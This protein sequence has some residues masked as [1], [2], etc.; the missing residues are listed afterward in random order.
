MSR[1]L[2]FIFL[3]IILMIIGCSQNNLTTNTFT[4]SVN[5]Q[6]I[7]FREYG[8]NN[9][10]E[11]LFI[12]G[13]MGSS[14]SFTNVAKGIS[15]EFNVT[16][17]DLP[18][19]GNSG[20]EIDFSID[21]LTELVDEFINK[22]YTK[23]V[24]LVGYSLGG[25]IANAI[26]E[27][28]NNKVNSYVLIDPWFSNNT[29]TDSLAFNF[30]SVIEKNAKNSWATNNDSINYVKEMNPD[31]SEDQINIISNNRFDYDI[32]I[33][34]SSVQKGTL[35]RNLNVPSKSPLLLIKPAASLIK[36]SQ[37]K[38]LS[39]NFL[40]LKVQAIPDTTHMIIFEEP[41]SISNL[42]KNFIK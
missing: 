1:N 21:K 31:L 8:N 32:K 28:S 23:P 14:T 26:S 35:I 16:L 10:P 34:D 40:N 41:E 6:E 33:W 38:K 24:T 11:I 36:E 29:S 13:L 22:K 19:H 3:T 2:F 4:S 18:G 7:Y 12:H 17:I 30:L 5:G 20:L 27:K 25:T 37:I 9:N 39:K 15:T 42:I